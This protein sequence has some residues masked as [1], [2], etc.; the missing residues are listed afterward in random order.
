[1]ENLAL[2]LEVHHDELEQIH[3]KHCG[4]IVPSSRSDLFCCSGCSAV[5]RLLSEAHLDG[6]Y[7]LRDEAGVFRRPAPV[8]PLA[9]QLNSPQPFLFLDDLEF[10]SELGIETFFPKVQFYLEGI[11][12]TA[13]LWLIEK[14]PEIL[15][16]ELVSARLD[17]QNSVVEL[18]FTENGSLS[19]V[20]TYLDQLGYRPHPLFTQKQKDDL[21]KRESRT[22]ATKVA[23]AGAL[24]GNIMIFAIAIYAGA[25]G[26]IKDHFDW[27]ILFLSLPVFFYSATPIYY[28]AYKAIAHRRWSVDIP[29]V[30]ALV[31]GF[32]TSVYSVATGGD[33]NYLDSLTGLIFL[34]SG[35]RYFLLRLQK[36]AFDGMQ[37]SESFYPAK[38][39]RNENEYVWVKDLKAGDVV[40]VPPGLRI[41]VD[42]MVVRG[43]S[44]VNESILSGESLPKKVIEREEVFAGAYNLDAPLWIRV[45]VSG[46]QTRIGKIAKEIQKFEIHRNDTVKLAE[47]VAKGFTLAVLVWSAAV[48]IY[49]SRTHSMFD[50]FQRVLAILIVSCPCAFAIATP[51]ALIQAFQVLMKRGVYMKDPNEIEKVASIQAVA[52]DK[53]GTLTEGVLEVEGVEWQ[54]GVPSALKNYYLGCVRALEES[55]KH[56]VGRALSRFSDFTLGAEKTELRVGQNIEVVGLGVS[57]VID[58]QRFEIKAHPGLSGSS[59]RSALWCDSRLLAVFSLKDR[60][61]GDAKQVVDALKEKKMAVWM[62][63]GDLAAPAQSIATELG[64]QSE[65]VLSASSPEGKAEWLAQHP[66]TLYVG[67]GA[68]DGLALSQASMAIA[69]HGA[70]DISMKAA[71]IYLTHHS[72]KGVL[73]LFTVS[74]ETRK[75]LKRHLI[76]TIL[77]NGTTITLA[78][79]GLL[80][81]LIAAVLMPVSSVLILIS[82]RVGTRKLRRLKWA[83]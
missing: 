2:H 51:L 8:H 15:P 26:F 69:A 63:S 21:I 58:D 68:N 82:T 54:G 74:E 42:G 29:I 23:L 43:Q 31:A 41:P 81:P 46:D 76:F 20:A 80:N 71:N 55:S 57:G 66:G 3:C 28:N 65:R 17:I 40:E 1:M 53:T 32:I 78:T 37:F 70:L 83:S 49:F 39:L 34:L 52:F 72:L 79:M 44:H 59:I 62:I 16:Q 14:M 35:S 45:S 19:A 64:I 75:I 61:H 12:C 7:R 27:I 24:S 30:I 60:L 6:Y 48:F 4:A 10:R 18:A 77:Y 33:Q 11:H 38:I 22:M 25:T 67:D 36:N 56:P 73:D 50:S 9:E 5:Y 13:C 47:K